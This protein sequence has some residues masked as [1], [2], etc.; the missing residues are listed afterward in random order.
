MVAKPLCPLYK[1]IIK[2]LDR[3][4]Y[5]EL[6]YYLI[7]PLLFSYFI[8]LIQEVILNSFIHFPSPL[9]R[10]SLSTSWMKSTN[11]TSNTWQIWWSSMISR[12]R[13]H[14]STLLMKVW[15]TFN[16]SASWTWVIP[17]FSR[18]PRKRP[19]TWWYKCECMLLSYYLI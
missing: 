12:R 6:R 4:R 2:P 5:P 7:V 11:E 9:L 3:A 18:L 13:S 15:L 14:V 16:K 17:N 8:V 10:I 1:N 19:M